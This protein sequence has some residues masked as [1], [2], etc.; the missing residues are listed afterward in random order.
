MWDSFAPNVKGLTTAWAN[1][2][3]AGNKELANEASADRLASIKKSIRT[4]SKH[5]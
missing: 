2:L 4:N 1:D 5:L 3:V